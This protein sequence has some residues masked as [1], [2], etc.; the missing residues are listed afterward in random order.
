MISTGK[1]EVDIMKTSEVEGWISDV[2]RKERELSSRGGSEARR[3]EEEKL[4]DYTE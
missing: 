2:R 4:K 3:E 1:M